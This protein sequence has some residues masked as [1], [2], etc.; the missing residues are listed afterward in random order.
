MSGG[1]PARAARAL[2]ALGR[3]GARGAWRKVRHARA[4]D[5]A[6]DAWRRSDAREHSF[7]AL[8]PAARLPRLLEMPPAATLPGGEQALAMARLHLEHRF[9]L[10]GSGWVRVRHGAECGGIEDVRFPP[11]PSVDAD[12]GGA[13]LD[14]RVNPANLAEARRVWSL[15]GDPDYVPI[16]WQLDFRSGYRWSELAW[17]HDVRFGGERGAD[18]KVPWELARLQHLPPLAWAYA[19]SAAGDSADPD[20]AER[21]RREFRAQVL[22]FIATNPPRWG[23]NWASPMDVAIRAANLAVAYDLFRAWG[24]GFDAPFERELERSLRAHARHVAATLEW[25]PGLRGNHYLSNVAGLL[26]AVAWLPADG[27]SD[28]W[29]HFAASE[30]I[31]ETAFQ[32]LADGANFECSTSY[33]RLSGEMVMLGTALLLGMDE[34]LRGLRPRGRARMRTGPG[35]PARALSRDRTGGDGAESCVPAAH[36]ARL[37]RIAAFTAHVAA[38]GFHAHLVGD[39]DSGRFVR[40]WP[41]A[42]LGTAAD[43]RAR[44]ASLRG[45][46]D[47]PDDACWPDVRHGDHRGLLAMA[48]ALLAPAPADV[49][50]G[51]A[52]AAADAA[53]VAALARGRRLAGGGPSPAADASVGGDASI[54]PPDGARRVRLS[55][56]SGD[57]WTGVRRLAYPAFGLYIYRSPGAYLAIRCGGERHGTL[58][59][60]HDDA[61]AVELRRGAEGVA[62][63]PGTYVYTALP[64]LREWYR[65]AAA[66]FA[67]RV[68]GRQA[69]R[70]GPGLFH[71]TDEARSRCLAFGDAG[72]LGVLEGDG[73]RVF[74]RVEL[75]DEGVEVTDWAE[76]GELDVPAPAAGA[77]AR[78]DGYGRRLA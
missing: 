31:G 49:R 47:L 60:A 50:A 36:V 15:I 41:G 27:E 70:R 40:L 52:P 61:L 66:H 6:R 19:L 54:P 21:C 55:I 22:D 8:P 35:Q 10:L 25:D 74:R 13:W 51:A 17:Y 46:R 71:A 43:A 58:G 34:R 23:V 7:G 63:D 37:A 56:G 42:E 9:D 12:A 20:F 59:H 65:S 39:D 75:V 57:A 44:L 28:A 18:V 64:E 72:F 45:G 53:L 16:D 2:R 68:R 73:Y 5:A 77:G 26:F 33:H 24:A 76:G 3:L 1:L 78:C 62:V 67:P 11:S 4:R 32:F 48:G 30:L 29:L 14:G 38:P 69:L